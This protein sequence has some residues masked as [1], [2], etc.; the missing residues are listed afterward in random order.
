MNLVEFQRLSKRTMPFNGEPQNP[1][2]FENML[3]NYAMGLLGEAVELLE[4][5]VN[6]DKEIIKEI[7]DVCHYAVG[8][9]MITKNDLP[10]K[11]ML[12]SESLSCVFNRLLFA[13]KEISEQ[14]KKH[15]YHRHTLDISPMYISVIFDCLYTLMDYYSP[16]GDALQMN[17]DKLKTRYPDKFN[18]EDSIARKDVQA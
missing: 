6:G 7:G 5:K 16:K 2:E 8:I 14:A 1:I 13:S 9:A 3:G 11:P 12:L 4:A 18:V 10:N 17:I 15:I